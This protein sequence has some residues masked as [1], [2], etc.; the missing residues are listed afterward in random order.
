MIAKCGVGG[1]TALGL[2]FCLMFC[3]DARGQEAQQKETGPVLKLTSSSFEADGD[4]PA[5]Y[6]CD[7]ANVSPTLAWT[8]AP[9][10][11]RGF[12]LI[13]DDPDTPK[14]A[15]THWLIY[16]LPVGTRLLP[17][18]VPTSKKLADGSMQGKNVRGK[19][20]YTGPCPE[21]GGPA[22]HYFFKLYALD[23]KTNLKPNAKKEEV[24]AA[25]KGHILAKAELIGRFKH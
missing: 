22:H 8:D 23:A 11:T 1:V 21:K 5:K 14:G 10:A 24:E 25:M 9:A 16:D 19:S 15:V 3:L 17:E 7:G 18:G 4:I 6:S 20:G 2:L 13:M 12:A